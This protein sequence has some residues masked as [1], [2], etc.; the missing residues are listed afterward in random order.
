[1]KERKLKY[2]AAALIAHGN[3]SVTPDKK[4]RHG[5]TP[6]VLCACVPLYLEV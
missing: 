4:D 2:V 6:Q 5:L 1:M 3:I